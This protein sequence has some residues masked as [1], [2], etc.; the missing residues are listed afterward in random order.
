MSLTSLFCINQ[1]PRDASA[2]TMSTFQKVDMLLNT[3]EHLNYIIDD[4]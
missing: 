4:L 2:A 3:I 1:M